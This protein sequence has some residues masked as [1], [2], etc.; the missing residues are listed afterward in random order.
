MLTLQLVGFLAMVPPQTLSMVALSVV[1]VGMKGWRA[2]L[3]SIRGIATFLELAM[4]TTLIATTKG[5]LEM[6][7]WWTQCNSIAQ[8][9][10]SSLLDLVCEHHVL[11]LAF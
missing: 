4:V 6:D 10:E 5:L 9:F 11:V 1:E 2:A 7:C 3:D 8:N